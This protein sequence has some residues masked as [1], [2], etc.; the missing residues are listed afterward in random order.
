[1][2]SSSSS[3]TATA[4][5]SQ[6]QPSSTT[7]QQQIVHHHVNGLAVVTVGDNLMS[8]IRQ[9]V[10]VRN[11]V[12]D[13]HD[14]DHDD[15]DDDERLRAR[16]TSIEVEF[17]CKEGVAC[18]AGQTRK[19]HAKMLKKG[20]RTPQPQKPNQTNKMTNTNNHGDHDGIVTPTTQIA[21][22]TIK[23]TPQQKRKP[24]VVEAGGETTV[25]DDDDDLVFVEEGVIP[26]YACVWGTIVELNPHI[27]RSPN[28]LL[29]DPLMDGHLAIIH[30]I[31]T[32]PP[33]RPQPPVITD[34]Q[35]GSKKAQ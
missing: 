6:L 30:P 10:V 11:R 4:T 29:E 26:F 12:D 25:D 8:L 19:K 35:E 2:T 15:D 5:K 32:F 31:G 21:L 28:L 17:T 16:I 3:A 34:P 33:P 1:M 23:L 9:A 22:V 7:K 24:S 14:Y 13:Y 18:N 27:L 20:P